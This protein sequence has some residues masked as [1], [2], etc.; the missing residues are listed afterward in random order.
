MKIGD[1][2]VPD[3]ATLLKVTLID[4]CFSRFLNCANSTKFCKVSH[5]KNSQLIFAVNW[6]SSFYIRVTLIFNG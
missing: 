6:S 1:D 4:G 3:L 2:P 5:V